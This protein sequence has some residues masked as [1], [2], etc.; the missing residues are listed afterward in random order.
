[1]NVL[2][3]NIRVHGLEDHLRELVNAQVKLFLSMRWL[4]YQSRTPQQH[5]RKPSTDEDGLL[6]DREVLQQ[7]HRTALDHELDVAQI[8]RPLELHQ[9]LNH[10]IELLTGPLLHLQL[11][12]MGTRSS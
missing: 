1:M 5:E 8:V 6:H 11:P 12:R 10:V 9:Q 2:P 3:S 4:C 7:R